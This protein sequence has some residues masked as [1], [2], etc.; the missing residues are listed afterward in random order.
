MRDLHTKTKHL[1]GDSITTPTRGLLVFSNIFQ[2]KEAGLRGSVSCEEAAWPS[3][4]S[5]RSG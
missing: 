5:M 1:L 2:G 4:Q 3:R